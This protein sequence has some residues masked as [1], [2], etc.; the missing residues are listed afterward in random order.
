MNMSQ[1]QNI[2]SPM[3]KLGSRPIFVTLSTYKGVNK[4]HLRHYRL[5][6][7]GLWLPLKTGVALNFDEWENFK[8]LIDSI[9]MEY[10]RINSQQIE[11]I[12]ILDANFL[13]Q[14]FLVQ[15][16]AVAISTQ[17]I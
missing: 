12:P 11:T 14:N 16:D 7:E 3:W 8:S 13:E 9:D 17:T 6:A 10:R 1:A 5:S 15:K 2:A 4:V